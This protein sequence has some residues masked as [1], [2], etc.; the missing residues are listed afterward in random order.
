MQEFT[1]SF[2][3]FPL[4]I[5]EKGSAG[6]VDGEFLIHCDRWHWEIEAAWIYVGPRYTLL[7]RVTDNALLEKMRVYF[8]AR[9]GWCAAVDD[10]HT[11]IFSADTLADLAGDFKWMELRT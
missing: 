8:M 10:Q 1:A 6:Y 7:E 11:E 2:E 9:K 3:E 4:Y 5:G